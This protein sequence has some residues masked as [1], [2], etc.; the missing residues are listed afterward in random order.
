MFLN[1]IFI[2][3]SLFGFSSAYFGTAKHGV[4]PFAEPS[5]VRPDP[6]VLYPAQL[7]IDQALSNQRDVIVGRK[8]HIEALVA[9]VLY[10]F[11]KTC[12]LVR[13]LVRSFVCYQL[14]SGLAH[15]FF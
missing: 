15:Y 9:R 12:S 13:S 10:C 1:L 5:S 8:S 7:C 3:Y 4:I 14:F 6:S 11:S 2:M